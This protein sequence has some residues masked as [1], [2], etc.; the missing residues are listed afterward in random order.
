MNTK[1][2]FMKEW[3]QIFKCDNCVWSA[4]KNSLNCHVCISF[5]QRKKHLLS[6]QYKIFLDLLTKKDTVHEGKKCK[7]QNQIKF[8][9]K[10]Y[11]VVKSVVSVL[12][13]G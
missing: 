1:W 12:K 9:S 4:R 7:V 8:G 5:L 2:Q 13:S 11:L 10:L 3:I 6:V